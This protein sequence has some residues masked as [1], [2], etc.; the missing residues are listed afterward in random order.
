VTLLNNGHG[1]PGS[2]VN[3]DGTLCDPINGAEEIWKFLSAHKR[4]R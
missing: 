3:A 2:M 1:W 4:Q